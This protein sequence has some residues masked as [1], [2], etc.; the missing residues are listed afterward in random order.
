MKLLVFIIFP[1]LS[2]SQ[3]SDVEIIE[4]NI[5]ILIGK[6][7]DAIH[8]DESISLKKKENKDTYILQ[9]GLGREIY[10]KSIYKT[11]YR[12]IKF[13]LDE[14]DL[15]RFYTFFKDTFKTRLARK[16]TLGD[17]EIMA[18]KGIK[19]EYKYEDVLTIKIIYKNKGAY[20]QGNNTFNLEENQLDKLFNK[21]NS[22]IIEG[23]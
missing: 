8:S 13:D 4:E 19:D 5:P 7:K 18:Q 17:Y 15:N 6:T 22:N 1:I 20:Y 2:F 3:I 14:K 11:G 16:I 9:Y 23:Y 21:D 12:S 10:L